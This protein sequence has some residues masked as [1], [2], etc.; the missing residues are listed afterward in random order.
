MRSRAWRESGASAPDESGLRVS[1]MARLVSVAVLVWGLAVLAVRY[2]E[3]MLDGDLFWH[4]KYAEQMLGRG[5][6][7]T[8]HTLY[9]WTPTSNDMIYC[10]WLAELVLYKLYQVGGLPILFALRYLCIGA[11][12]TLML[13]HARALGLLGEPLTWAIVLL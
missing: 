9:S 10:A 1:G 5:T 2:A 8:D 4:L 6:L 3:P 13:M 11:V 12:G 7:V